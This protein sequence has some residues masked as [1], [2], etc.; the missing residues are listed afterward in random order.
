MIDAELSL[1]RDVKDYPIGR[2]SIQESELRE[3]LPPIGSP[4][5]ES[6]LGFRSDLRWLLLTQGASAR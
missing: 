2:D 1:V 6:P 5:A 4:V 3:G